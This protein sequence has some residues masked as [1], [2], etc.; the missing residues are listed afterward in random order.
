MKTCQ[1]GVFPTETPTLPLRLSLNLGLSAG[2]TLGRSAF[3]PMDS[4]MDVQNKSVLFFLAM[5][6]AW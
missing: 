3:G 1:E 4:H 2:E 6:L 5:I